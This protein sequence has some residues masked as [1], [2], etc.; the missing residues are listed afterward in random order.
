MSVS[1]RR[2]ASVPSAFDADVLSIVAEAPREPGLPIRILIA[3]DD[4]VILQTLSQVLGS[5]ADLEIIGL[6][7]DAAEA[8][9]VASLRRPDVALLDVRMPCGGGPRAARE[10][11]QRSPSTRLI[12]LSANSDDDSVDEMLA[13]GATSFLVKDQSIDDI[14][15]AIHRTIDG[16]ATISQAVAKH[17]AVELGS[18]L[19][20]ERQGFEDDL[21]KELRI[22]ELVETGEGLE[23]VYEPIVEIATGRVVGMEAL[24]RFLID[25]DRTPDLWFAEAAE[26]GLGTELQIVTVQQALGALQDLPP[27][28]FV[29]VNVDPEALVSPS[30]AEVMRGMQADRIVA[31]LTEHVAANDYPSLLEALA[32]LKAAGLRVAIDD[33]GAGFSSLRHVLELS[34]DIIKLD[35]SISRHVDTMDNHR[36]LAAALVG[37][38]REM[39]I[40]LVAEGVETQ[41]EAREL[42]DLGVPWIQGFYVA[43]PGPLPARPRPTGT[44]GSH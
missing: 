28:V 38:T 23:I 25:P 33:T 24:S 19:D 1:T 14:I 10:I 13:G 42:E 31:E 21:D 44:A 34:P 17:V 8:I 12:A 30:F 9:R 27:D 3:D 35:I 40:D 4:K 43:R 5:Y 29:S 20:R 11:L 37:F 2:L 15:D 7:Q 16:S 36:A 22:S 6:V 39:G 26:V 41:A 18:R 32:P